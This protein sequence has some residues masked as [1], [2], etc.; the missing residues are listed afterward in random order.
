[1]DIESS[2][3]A[4]AVAAHFARARYATH[5]RNRQSLQNWQQRRLQYFLHHVLPQAAAFRG[6]EITSLN[7]LPYMDKTVFMG[8]FSAYNT[9]H[10]ALDDAR[11]VAIQAETSRD[12][13]PMLGELTVGL[14]SGT[15]GNQGVFLVSQQ[16]RLQWAGI[17]LARTLPANML[18][19]ILQ[20]WKPP[21]RIAFFLRANS[22][23]Y[24]T[25]KS[26]RI[27]FAFYDLLQ[28]AEPALQRLNATQPDVLVGPPSLLC[29]LAQDLQQGKLRIAPSRLISV[30]EVLEEADSTLLQQTF[31]LVPHQIYQ[32]TEGFL[33]YTCE[34]GTLHLNETYIHFEPEWLD[35]AQT[36]FMPVITDF[37]RRTQ[38]LVRY[39][40]N[41]ILRVSK[42]SCACGRAER[43]IA[44]IEGR[45][46]EVLWLPALVTNQ[47]VAVYPD[48]LRRAMLLVGPDIEEFDVEQ[49]G[50]ALRVALRIRQEAHS[51]Q[52]V[53][54]R[55]RMELAALW[56]TLKAQAPELVFENWAPPVKGAKRR[57]VRCQQAPEGLPCMF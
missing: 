54:E 20:P 53:I 12:F 22:N 7:D 40:L 21:L 30:A 18:A 8:N 31:G 11:A 41:D 52:H 5:F 56:Q 37:T 6:Q 55:V 46:D 50:M 43:A 38:L 39:R 44:A 35:A 9:H 1:M 51:P 26:R 2:F 42:E 29:A 10:I 15:S 14:S 24:D 47:P 45:Q 28:G 23:L 17:M 34:H 13:L 32:A 3:N 36:R 27:D 16:E 25:L 19:R 57:R 4:L 48:F 49:H 33:G